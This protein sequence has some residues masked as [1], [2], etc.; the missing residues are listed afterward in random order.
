MKQ[1]LL[2]MIMLITIITQ[3]K[4]SSIDTNHTHLQSKDKRTSNLILNAVDDVNSSNNPLDNE[5]D[6]LASDY[7]KDAVYS[8]QTNRVT[9]VASFKV[10]T[11]LLIGSNW[12]M[13]RK[14]NISFECKYQRIS[15]NEGLQCIP[16]RALREEDFA[17]FIWLELWG[18]TWTAGRKLI[19]AIPLHPEELTRKLYQLSIILVILV[20]VIC[21][22]TYYFINMKNI[23]AISSKLSRLWGKNNVNVSPPHSPPSSSPSSPSTHYL[24]ASF[25]PTNQTFQLPPQ[26]FKTPPKILTNSRAKFYKG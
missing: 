17:E 1:T 5:S 26:L 2:L 4:T 18:T 9:F 16:V 19:L 12:L 23:S 24:S 20:V 25:S 21:A 15:Q 14:K 7:I 13:I 11:R 10:G 6:S 3:S 8:S 22:P